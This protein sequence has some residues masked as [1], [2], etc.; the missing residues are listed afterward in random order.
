MRIRNVGALR[1]HLILASINF[2]VATAYAHASSRQK[3]PWVNRRLTWLGDKGRTGNPA[4]W[5]SPMLDGKAFKAL[6][7]D[8]TDS[9]LVPRLRDP[10]LLKAFAVLGDNPRYKA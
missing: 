3:A 2:L 10:A 9:D 7:S 1:D 5:S 6:L 4:R 8:E